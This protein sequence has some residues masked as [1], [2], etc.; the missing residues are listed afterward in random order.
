[1][2]RRF[3]SGHLSSTEDWKEENINPL[4]GVTNMVDVML[5]LA[6]GIMMALIMHWNVNIHSVQD[7]QELKDAQTLNDKQVQEVE[8]NNGLQEKGTV[9]QDPA[10]GKY[11][12]KV[13]NE[14]EQ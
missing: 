7:V 2:M 10:T 1:M 14:D 8:D 5:V 11:Y 4:D 12:L 9:Y 13:D 3:G 6:V